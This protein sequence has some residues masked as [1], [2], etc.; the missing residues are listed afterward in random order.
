MRPGRH[1]TRSNPMARNAH[2]RL[3][4][5]ATPQGRNPYETLRRARAVAPVRDPRADFRRFVRRLWPAA[6]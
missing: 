2:P 3:R 4:L 6:A 1:G 5:V